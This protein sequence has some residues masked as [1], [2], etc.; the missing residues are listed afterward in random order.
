[1]P[2]RLAVTSARRRRTDG[3]SPKRCGISAKPWRTAWEQFTPFFAFPHEIRRLEVYTTNAIESLN[4][5]FRQTTR[6]MR[7]TNRGQR[8]RQHQRLEGHVERPGAALRRQDHRN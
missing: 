2:G 7:L 1:M 5:R 8:H 6:R 3:R 4:A